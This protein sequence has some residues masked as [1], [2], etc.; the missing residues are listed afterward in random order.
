MLTP[1][2]PQTS[3]TAASEPRWGIIYTAV[4]ATLAVVIGLLI[5]FSEVWTPG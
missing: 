5:L 1:D 3:P 4:I 2:P